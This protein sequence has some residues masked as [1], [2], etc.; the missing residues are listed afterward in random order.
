M[1]LEP[2]WVL[3]CAI[4]GHT[5]DAQQCFERIINP[6]GFYV[7]FCT[8]TQLA[9]EFQGQCI[10]SVHVTKED[11]SPIDD[12]DFKRITDILAFDG[13]RGSTFLAS[14]TYKLNSNEGLD[15]YGV[16]GK[17]SVKRCRCHELQAP[18]FCCDLTNM[19]NSTCY[20]TELL[21]NIGEIHE[22]TA[23]QGRNP[24]E[25]I[26]K[27]FDNIALHPSPKFWYDGEQNEKYISTIEIL[28]EYRASFTKEIEPSDTIENVKA[29]IHNKEGIPPD[30]QR[31]IFAGKRLEDG[32]TL[33]R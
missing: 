6:H 26:S 22:L 20:Y 24:V 29:K 14:G 13:P 3:P 11:Y 15:Q 33:V 9:L 8:V 19:V 7:R 5:S 21:F 1:A 25:I 2:G 30:Q 16:I 28:E 27:L 17:Y 23:E 31:L 12:H 32:R 18:D 4:N 10:W